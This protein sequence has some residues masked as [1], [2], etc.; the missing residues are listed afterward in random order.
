[1]FIKLDLAWGAALAALV[2]TITYFIAR[3]IGV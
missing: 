3:K 1:M 2:S